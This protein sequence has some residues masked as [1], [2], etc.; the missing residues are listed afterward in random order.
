M[1]KKIKKATKIIIILI[2]LSV[3]AYSLFSSYASMMKTIHSVAQSHM[4]EVANDAIHHAILKASQNSS[5]YG[6]LV[7]VTVG[8]GGEIRSL[9]LNPHAVNKFKSDI[10][11]EALKYLDRD[12]IH[13]INVPVGNFFGSEFLTGVGPEIK[14]QIVPFDI[15]NIDFK[16]KF[17][18][19]GINQVLHRVEVVVDVKIGAILPGYEG[20]TDVSS[21]AVVAESIIIGDVP[22][23]YLNVKK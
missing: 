17:T 16:S 18:P 13:I 9:M 21:S 11:V 5:S 3:A 4:E 1:Q 2:F 7:S 22:D 23:T 10:S 15:V 12:D 20:I 6:E 19:A 14:L 8:D